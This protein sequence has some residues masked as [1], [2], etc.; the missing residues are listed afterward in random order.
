MTELNRLGQNIRRLRKL[1]GMNQTELA[2]KADTRLAT[3]SDLE[4]GNNR[5]PGWKLLTRIASVLNTTLHDL[6]LHDASSI[7]DDEYAELAPGLA[8]LVAN[9]DRYLAPG[10]QRIALREVEWLRK[11]PGENAQKINCDSYL[12]V[13]RHYRIL[14]KGTGLHITR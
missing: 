1:K 13:L 12:Q 9:Q 7:T 5:N 3:I 8:D 10:E 11:A 4:N 6:T 14:D 2:F